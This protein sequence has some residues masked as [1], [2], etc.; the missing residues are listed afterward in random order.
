[1]TQYTN[2]Q[3]PQRH[4]VSVKD[5]T[6]SALQDGLF[7]APLVE[8]GDY[9]ASLNAKSFFYVADYQSRNSMYK[10]VSGFSFYRA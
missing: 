5:W 7:T 8:T 3:S 1:M 6:L 10:Q 4:P 2:W 9:H